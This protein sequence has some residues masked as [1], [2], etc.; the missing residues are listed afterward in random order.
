ML[1]ILGYVL[2]VWMS[3][4]GALISLAILSVFGYWLYKWIHRE[5]KAP[6]AEQH[7]GDAP[8]GAPRDSGHG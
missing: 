7:V 2:A 6:G 1:D 3:P 8:G 4:T 5:P